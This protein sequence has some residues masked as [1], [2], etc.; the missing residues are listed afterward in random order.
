[1]KLIRCIKSFIRLLTPDV[2]A[3][4]IRPFWLEDDW[5]AVLFDGDSGRQPAEQPDRADLHG[6]RGSGGIGGNPRGWITAEPGVT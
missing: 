4:P 5:S 2:D 1:M 3:K 6:H